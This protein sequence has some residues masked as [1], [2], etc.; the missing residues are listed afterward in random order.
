MKGREYRY[1]FRLRPFRAGDEVARDVAFGLP[2]IPAEPVVVQKKVGWQTAVL[3]AGV[4][5]GGILAWR[6]WQKS[7]AGKD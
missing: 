5:A 6:W 7:K 3:A 4:L 1:A 2:T